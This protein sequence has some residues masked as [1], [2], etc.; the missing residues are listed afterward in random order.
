[1]IV[2]AAICTSSSAATTR[3]YFQTRLWLGVS[4]RNTDST[5]SIGASSGLLRKYS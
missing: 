1:M 3:K 4:G 5:G 2:P